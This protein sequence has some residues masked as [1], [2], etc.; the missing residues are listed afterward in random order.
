MLLSE[1]V[2]KM[3][4]IGETP[5]GDGVY[6][7]EP[8]MHDMEDNGKFVAGSNSDLST[9][10]CEKLEVNYTKEERDFFKN[11]EDNLRKQRQS[12]E[13]DGKF[14]EAKKINYKMKSPQQIIKVFHAY[15]L[16]KNPLT[17]EEMLKT[18]GFMSAVKER[19]PRH[20][21]DKKDIQSIV[22][23][24]VTRLINAMKEPP[25]L[26]GFDRADFSKAYTDFIQPFMET[27]KQADKKRN[28]I[29]I[30]PLSSSS[31]LVSSFAQTLSERLGGA[32]IESGA[33]LKNSW[34]RL[35]KWTT[36][37]KHGDLLRLPSNFHIKMVDE[38][39]N[40]TYSPNI[41]KLLRQ[42]KDL[43]RIL[44]D[45]ARNVADDGEE[46]V[47]A[48][49]PTDKLKELLIALRHAIT[50]EYVDLKDQINAK[51]N[52]L[53]TY[54]R[55]HKL[56]S[57]L[58]IKQHRHTPQYTKIIKDIDVLR[59]KRDSLPKADIAITRPSGKETIQY[60]KQVH[61]VNIQR[62]AKHY[63][64]LQQAYEYALINWEDDPDNAAKLKAAED[65]EA[66]L[67]SLSNEYNKSLETLYD[68]VLSNP[69]KIHNAYARSGGDRGKGYYRFQIL[70]EDYADKLNGKSIILVDD[71][72]DTGKSIIDAVKSMAAVGVIPERIIAMT[73]HKFNT[74]AENTK[75]TAALPAAR[76]E[77]LANIRSQLA[78]NARQY[79]N[80]KLQAKKTAPDY[81]EKKETFGQ[82]V[83]RTGKLPGHGLY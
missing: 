73:P 77:E 32:Q 41:T 72:V 54:N 6:K 57:D 64:S 70:H 34:P 4:K 8:V 69:F 38:M 79:K 7:H 29:I 60:Q 71:N 76:R 2:T 22:D 49:T 78:S 1:V 40:H 37:I 18:H 15:Q 25:V 42:I 23:H 17:R 82:H 45:A 61:V 11:L 67:K 58:A 36:T 52:E 28:N 21:M 66:Q 9:M 53:A 33:L 10:G 55:T 62:F 31:K 35:S 50:D 39:D 65:L 74:S 43:M 3:S 12:L 56:D 80:E 59:K 81:N 46:V 51:L 30:V 27:G 19:D 16:F 24:S 48:T 47:N 75:K 5:E 26:K 13:A 14:D 44:G 83:A 68:A 20:L 63:D